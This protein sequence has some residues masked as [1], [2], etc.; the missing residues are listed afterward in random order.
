M[1]LSPEFSP[2]PAI[3]GG[4]LIGLAA[5]WMMLSSGRIAGIS[6]IFSGLLQPKAG[7]TGWRLAFV[8]GLLLAGAVVSATMPGAIEVTEARSLWM[9]GLAGLIVGFGVRLG[10]GCTSGHGVCGLSRFS[11]R[12]LV[13]TSSFMGTGILTATLIQALF[14]GAL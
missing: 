14:G 2:L 5:S 10:N 13:A 4:A 8:A 1:T 6:G 11:K 7:D 3:A 12:S 9:T